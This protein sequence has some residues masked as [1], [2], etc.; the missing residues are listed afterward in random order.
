MAK[1]IIYPDSTLQKKLCERPSSSLVDISTIS[2]IFRKVEKDGDQALI[3]LTRKYDRV[4]LKKIIIGKNEL[5]KLSRRTPK[6]LRNAMQLA[7]KNIFNFHYKTFENNTA[8]IKQADGVR[9]W[10]KKAPISPVGLYIPGG[11][12]PLFSTV[13]MLAIPASIAGCK[14]VVVCTPP[15]REGTLHPAIAFALDLCGIQTAYLCGGVQAVAA[16]ALGT[17]SVPRV[18]KIFGPGNAWVTAAKQYALIQGRVSIDLP[19]GPS[20]VLVIADDRANPSWV[21][22]DLLSQCEHGPESQ[23]VMLT[24][25]LN[26]AKSVS[27]EAKTQLSVLGIHSPAQI[28]WK[29]SRLIVLKNLQECF[30][31]SNRYAPEHLIL[32]M[33]GAS[34]FVHNVWNAGSVFIGPYSTEP[35]GDYITGPN[36]TL[37]TSGYA[38]AW[39]GVTVES[40]V[41]TISFQEISKKG[42]HYLGPY[43][44]TMAEAE[45]LHAHAKAIQIRLENL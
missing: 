36:H 32:H 2:K 44:I 34:T 25:S 21:A 31:F 38:A 5:K 30:D 40:F 41:K 22:A 39:S 6:E 15:N 45:G 24:T 11:R 1:I 26:L 12:A 19:A 37:P 10:K 28:S 42:I 3:E 14:D 16:M 4:N 27:H 23:S 9:A 8:I 13:L 20:E 29:N 7:Y 18:H 33:S 35:L 17:Q 43:A